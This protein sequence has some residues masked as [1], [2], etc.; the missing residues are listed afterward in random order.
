MSQAAAYPGAD[1]DRIHAA[2]GVSARFIGTKLITAEP[3]TR[4]AYNAL[5]GWQ[6]LADEDGADAGYLVEYEPDGKP[7]VVGRAGYVSWTP[8]ASFDAAYRPCHA[9]TFGLALEALQRGARVT[10]SGWNGKGL[11]LEYRPANGVDLPFIRMSYPVHSAAYPQG[12][13]VPWLASQTDML[14]EDWQLV[15]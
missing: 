4:G 7:N 10:R 5:R 14:A 2:R 13:R 1:I 9:L 15:E 6:L 12:A 8:K 3:M 11:W